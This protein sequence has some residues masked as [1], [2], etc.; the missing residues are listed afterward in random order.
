MLSPYLFFPFICIYTCMCVFIYQMWHLFSRF[1]IF[2]ILLICI[3]V[4]KCICM[5]LCAHRDQKRE[6]VIWAVMNHVIWALGTQVRSFGRV[7]SALTAHLSGLCAWVNEDLLITF[8]EQNCYF[9][10]MMAEGPVTFA[11]LCAVVNFTSIYTA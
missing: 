9:V 2:K 6:L 11:R 5:Y 3:C 8:T 10:L 7:A 1:I 4:S